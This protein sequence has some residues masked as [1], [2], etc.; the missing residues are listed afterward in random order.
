MGSDGES[1]EV[2]QQRP[3][4]KPD[5]ADQ[6]SEDDD[7]SDDDL[8]R[9]LSLAVLGDMVY[10][11]LVFRMILAMVMMMESICELGTYLLCFSEKCHFTK[12][13]MQGKFIL[14]FYDTSLFLSLY[15][16]YYC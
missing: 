16:N 7:H 15:N 12:I 11:L 4:S 9:V 5:S 2:E 13:F 10:Y 1:S 8:D 14:F 6:E 3:Y